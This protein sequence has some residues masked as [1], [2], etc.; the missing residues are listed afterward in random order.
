[1]SGTPEPGSPSRAPGPDPTG[2]GPEAA[3]PASDAAAPA[4][5]AADPATGGSSAAGRAP[6]AGAPLGGTTDGE[7][8]RGAGR[9][10]TGAGGAP[11]GS[12]R[13][14]AGSSAGGPGAGARV[15]RHRRPSDRVVALLAGAGVALVLVAGGVVGVRAAAGSDGGDPPVAAG[16]TAAG[17]TEP[18]PVTRKPGA[19]PSWGP[20][21]GQSPVAAPTDRA[22]AGVVPTGVR[23]PAIGV[24]ATSLVPLEIIP[25]SGEL[26]AP[27]EFDQ[28]GW[29]AAGPVPG[30]PGPAVIA[31]H[32][33]S[34]A[35]PAVFFRLKELKAGDH[36]LVPRSDGSTV[37]FTVTAVERY[38]KNAFPTQKVH[39]P[40]PDRELRLI[41][42]GGSFDY[43][44]RSYRD[45]IVVYA[46]A[47]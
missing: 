23:I 46:I 27:K 17:P 18:A 26:E 47:S 13:A 4:P 5:G 8:E 39:G 7:P 32:V 35:G 37:R 34:R 44:K 45:N 30:E 33:D 41:T 31:A 6:A 28:T 14:A 20:V 40:T 1:M 38:P 2:P 29:Y 21:S 22:A 19:G 43:A 16:T 12:G 24:S 25:G 42:C 10:D 15:G 3:G 11:G 36:V 9:P